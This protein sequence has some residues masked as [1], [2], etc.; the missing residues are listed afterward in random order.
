MAGI[1]AQVDNFAHVFLYSYMVSE[2]EFITKFRG[3]SCL[4]I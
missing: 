2:R 4:I 1:T 3:G